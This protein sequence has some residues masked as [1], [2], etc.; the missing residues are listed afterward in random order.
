M[1]GRGKIEIK[2]K[3]KAPVKKKTGHFHLF[4]PC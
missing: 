1:E 4:I 2:T 3:I